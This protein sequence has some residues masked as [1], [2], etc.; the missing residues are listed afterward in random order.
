SD[1][2]WQRLGFV[3]DVAYNWYSETSD[4]KRSQHRR[5]LQGVLHPW[6][7]TMPHFVM[8]S[9]PRAFVGSQLCWQGTVLWEGA[10][11]SFAA[12][13]QAEFAC[14][15][16]APG[17]VGKRIFGVAVASDARLAMTLRPTSAVR[18]L[19]LYRPALALL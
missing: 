18:L 10:G 9:F 5:G 7:I 6:H 16:L 3:N 15:T 8:F 4:V 2:E 19:Q 1:A 11:G 13:P 12:L 17:D 14:R